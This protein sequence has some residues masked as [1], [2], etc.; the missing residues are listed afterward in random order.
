MFLW[1]SNIAIFYN[2][3]DVELKGNCFV[4][5]N[6]SVLNTSIFSN[7]LNASAPGGG[8]GAVRIMPFTSVLEASSGDYNY[9]ASRIIV[10]GDMWVG[11]KSLLILLTIV[12]LIIWTSTETVVAILGRMSMISAQTLPPLPAPYLVLTPQPTTVRP[13][14][15]L[16]FL[17]TIV[18]PIIWTSTE[19]CCGDLG[20]HVNDK[21]A[22]APANASAL[23][24]ADSPANDSAAITVLVDLVDNCSTDTL[25]LHGNCCG[26]LEVAAPAG[27]AEEVAVS[28]EEL[29]EASRVAACD[30]NVCTVL[31]V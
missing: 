23:P 29:H 21:C 3:K 22:D 2:T 17:L 26:D 13:S 5:N 7:T 24:C 18:A 25:D 30:C 16:L 19:T 14:Q 8:G 11:G 20:T 27:L 28:Q 31:T 1:L 6:L 15:C 4:S 10:A 12:A 9:N